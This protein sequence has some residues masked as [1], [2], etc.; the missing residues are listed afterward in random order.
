MLEPINL[1]LRLV[2]IQILPSL[3][4]FYLLQFKPLLICDMDYL[5]P[6]YLSFVL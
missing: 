3:K 2:T 5:F 6:R 4:F 1:R